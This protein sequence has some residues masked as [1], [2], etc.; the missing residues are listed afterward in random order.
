MIVVVTS[1][2]VAPGKEQEHDDFF[3]RVVSFCKKKAL[4]SIGTRPI[5]GHTNIRRLANTFESY[6]A[7]KDYQKEIQTD[8]EWQELLK[9]LREKQYTVPG[10]FTRAIEEV[11]E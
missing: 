7:W 11:V 2:A 10:S 1:G 3:K 9:E 5:T 4:S 6:A 8:P